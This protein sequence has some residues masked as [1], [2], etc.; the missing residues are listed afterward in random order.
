MIY[1]YGLIVFVKRIKYLSVLNFQADSN[2]RGLSSHARV[3]AVPL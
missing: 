1:L 2:I 3:F